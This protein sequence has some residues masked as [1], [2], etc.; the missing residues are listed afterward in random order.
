MFLMRRNAEFCEKDT[1]VVKSV[2]RFP[3]HPCKLEGLWSF[4]NILLFVEHVVS[5]KQSVS[6]YI[7]VFCLF[8]KKLFLLDLNS[9]Y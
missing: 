8:D 5:K 9:P 7:Y 4:K 2:Y 6:I 3:F 1:S